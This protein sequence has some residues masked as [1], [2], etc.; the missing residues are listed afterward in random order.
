M[1]QYDTHVLYV[2]RKPEGHYIGKGSAIVASLYQ[3]RHTEICVY[4]EGNVYSY[5]KPLSYTELVY[6][7]ASRQVERAPTIAMAVL[8]AV[9]LI[10][11]GRYSITAQ[12]VTALSDPAALRQWAPRTAAWIDAFEPLPADFMLL[13]VDNATR[14]HLLPWY[15]PAFIR[16]ADVQAFIQRA[17][18]VDREEKESDPDDWTPEQKEAYGRGDWREFSRLRGYTNEEIE[19]FGE[20]LRLERVVRDRHSAGDEDFTAALVHAVRMFDDSQEAAP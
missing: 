15:S 20:Y 14:Q 13:T 8:P 16:D 19:N 10:E 9:D 3:S 18:R 2:P 4:Y 1:S 7:A 6:T 11:V 12:R 17:R 5:A